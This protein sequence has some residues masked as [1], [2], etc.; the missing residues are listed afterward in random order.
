V[1]DTV[2]L[3]IR[4]EHLTLGGGDLTLAVDLIEP[5]G[6]ETLLHGRV[7]GRDNDAITVKVSGAVGS[8]ET[9]TVGV[10]ADQ[11]HVF[12]GVTGRRIDPVK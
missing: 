7:V 3:G 10:Q 2:T 11:A 4:P 6:S 5:L 8:V 9:V 1:G 12:D